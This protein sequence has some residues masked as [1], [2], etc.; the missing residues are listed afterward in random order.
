VVLDSLDTHHLRITTYQTIN[1]IKTR[2]ENNPIEDNFIATEKIHGCNFSIWLGVNENKKVVFQCASRSKFI[3]KDD[4]LYGQQYKQIVA[5]LS[6]KF[7]EIYADC[8]QLCPE[9]CTT[10][11]VILYGELYGDGVQRGIDYTTDNRK[12]IRF[13]DI[14]FPILPS[15]EG[16]DTEIQMNFINWEQFLKITTNYE[17]PTAPVINQGTFDEMLNMNNTFDSLI[18]K[19]SNNIAEGFVFKCVLEPDY[20][21]KE[22]KARLIIKSKTDKFSEIVANSGKQKSGKQTNSKK[23][24]NLNAL[25][26]ALD[27]INKTQYNEVIALVNENRLDAVLSND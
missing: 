23:G 16:D 14:A 5:D 21:I 11:I 9:Y 15:Y 3:S 13:F 8:M 12:E 7:E 18:M 2:L 22:N 17:L 25:I 1:F 10:N 24:F 4:G 20:K 26:D 19:K 6:P 27:E